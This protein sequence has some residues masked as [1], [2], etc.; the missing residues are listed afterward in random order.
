MRATIIVLLLLWGTPADLSLA[1]ESM[2]KSFAVPSLTPERE[3]ELRKAFLS[4]VAKD[5]ATRKESVAKRHIF[6]TDFIAESQRKLHEI[7]P[8]LDTLRKKFKK[9]KL[10]RDEEFQVYQRLSR[11]RHQFSQLIEKAKSEQR[12][13]IQQYRLLTRQEELDVDFRQN[14]L[15][16]A[17]RLQ[18]QGAVDEALARLD[19]S[20]LLEQIAFRMIDSV[21]ESLDDIEESLVDINNAILTHPIG[22]R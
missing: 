17:E 12:L 1:E 19:Q 8:Q 13:R 18:L 5:V 14:K 9:E 6:L 22:I 11:S 21:K 2:G 15:T 20:I 16:K 7:K 4:E 3:A 10:L